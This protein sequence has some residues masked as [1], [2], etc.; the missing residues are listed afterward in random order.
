MTPDFTRKKMQASFS[1]L[2]DIAVVGGI[3]FVV[4]GIVV[5]I[6]IWRVTKQLK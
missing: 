2:I 4:L 6:W 3:V 1:L 5:A